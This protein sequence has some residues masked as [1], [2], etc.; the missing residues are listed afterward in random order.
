VLAVLPERPLD[1]RIDGVERAGGFAVM[2][3]EVNEPDLFFDLVPAAA[4]RFANAI[5]AR[6]ARG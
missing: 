6:L 2:E 3:V 1:A 4:E 5:V